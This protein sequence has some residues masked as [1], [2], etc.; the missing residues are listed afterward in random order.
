[1]TLLTSLKNLFRPSYKYIYTAGDYGVNVADMGIAKLY[2]TQPNLRSVVS[3][4]AD[5]A[6]EVPLKV[7]RRESDTD[8]P[9]VIDSPAALLMRQPGPDLTAFEFK[10][11]MYTDLLLYERFMTLLLPDGKTDSGW[12][13]WPVPAQWITSY[14]GEDPYSPEYVIISP[15]SGPMEIPADKFILFHGYDPDDPMR[16]LSRIRALSESLYE[17]IES[18]KFRR[19][20]WH[21][22]G[23]FNAYVTRPKDVAAW[24]DS[25]FE[26]FKATFKNSWAGDNGSDAGGMPILEDGMEIKSIQFNAKEAEWSESVKL[27]REDCAAVFHVNPALI[28]PGTG[29]TYASAKDNARALYNDCLEPI[30]MQATDRLNLVLLK[31][32][33]EPT[34]DYIAYDITIKTEGTYE[35]KIQALQSAVGAPFLSRNEARARLDLPALD[36]GDELIT[37]LN[38]LVGGLASPSDTDPTVQRYNSTAEAI[39]HARMILGMKAKK[40][41]KSRSKPTEDEKEKISK[42]YRDFFGRQ[43]RSVLAKLG[44]DAE[45]WWDED[46]WNSELTDDLFKEAFDMSVAVGKEAVKN[47]FD[48]GSYDAD[49][50]ENYIKAMCRKR[51]EMMNQVTHDEIQDALDEKLDEDSL[52]ATP[53]G[54]FE[55]AKEDRAVSAGAAF[56]GALVSWSAMEACRQNDSGTAKIWKTWVVNSGNPRATHAQMN[57]ERVPYD[58]PFSNGAMWPGDVEALSAEEVAN[59]E[60]TVEIEVEA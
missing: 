23:R 59:C 56:A 8:R 38:V 55:Y 27:S 58:Q 41:K 1:M 13:L 36:G 25:A 15:P 5:N 17:Q 18:N 7:F 3:F 40:N 47:L 50:T 10:R 12:A 30:L 20:M 29:Q 52:K 43:A 57:G 19:Q 31:R 35:E 49:R 48:D 60:C 33:G 14:K 37:P 6:A 32:I 2:E 53:E 24:S 54:V 21:K 28:W 4:L 9:R 34:D 45:E 46:R 22:G 51:A 39:E 16:Q 44:A 11:R 26:R 42:V